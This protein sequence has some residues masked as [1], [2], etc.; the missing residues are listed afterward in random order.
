[1]SKNKLLLILLLFAFVAACKKDSSNIYQSQGILLGPD[2][3]ACPICGGMKVE[4]KNDTAK[5][6]PAFYR[7]NTDLGKL[8][9]TQ[10]LNYPVNISLNWYHNSASPGDTYIIVT[11][12]K[13]DN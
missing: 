2:L 1:M 5:N 8:G 10:A 6:H 4:I 3:G 11:K 7:T 12:L 13:I 9:L